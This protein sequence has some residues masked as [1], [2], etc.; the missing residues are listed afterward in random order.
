MNFTSFEFFGFFGIFF[1]LYWLVFNR[2]AGTQNLFLLA[3][4]YIFYVWW[5]WRFLL[6]L[7]ASSAI[8]FFIGIQ[9]AQS[10]NSRH[11]KLLLSLGLL[12]GLGGLI[13]FKY[14]NFFITSF[15]DG[16]ASIGVNLSVHTLDIILPLGIS[17][18]T[19]R[20]L[21]YLLDIDKRK[22]KPTTDW[23][24]FFNYVSFFP[25]LLSG[26]IDKAKMFIPQ[27]EKKREF[28]YEK[29][30]DGLRQIL[31]GF[32]KKIV[33]ADNCATFTNEI[34]DNFQSYHGATLL[35]GI[36]LFAIQLYCDF[37]GYS[38]MAIGFARMIGFD[39]TKNFNFPY[40][41][42]NIAD[43]WRRW[44]ISLTS[45]MTEYVFTPLSIAFR[46][47]GKMGLILAIVINL[48]LVGIWHGANWSFIFFGFMHGCLF[49]PLILMG[50]MNKKK[51]IAKG[52]FFPTFS[53]FLNIIGTFSLIM[54]TFVIFKTSSFANAAMY[55]KEMFSGLFHKGAYI[56]TLHFLQWK[57]LLLLML[58]IFL[59]LLTE[60]I[61]KEQDYAIEKLAAKWYKPLRWSFY[62]SL[63]I[64]VYYFAGE[65]QQFIY[66]QF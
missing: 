37:S 4:N 21:S 12:Q 5:D 40:F 58:I 46:D 14:F 2:N 16:F 59:F 49:I 52:R 31:W 17:Y 54:L 66:F 64:F 34:F 45:W 29:G 50:T 28:T 41:A 38:D 47:Y 25:T 32:F 24:V 42:Q 33:I 18:Y 26:P 20:T 39:I 27:L 48:T 11:R 8:N 60:W 22:I 65:R 23:V 44:H 36:F 10:M 56:E 51:T 7:I 30:T 9:L 15:K 19:F 43:F 57:N 6:L 55:Y 13:Y 61:G 63:L 1:F 62:L 35:L 53:Q 3:A